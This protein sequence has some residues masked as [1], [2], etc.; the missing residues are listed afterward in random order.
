MASMI[1]LKES[2]VVRYSPMEKA[3]IKV[4]ERQPEKKAD[5]ELLT[6]KVY[7][8]LDRTP[9]RTARN[10]MSGTVRSL[11]KKLDKNKEEIKLIQTPFAGPYATKVAIVPRLARAAA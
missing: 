10:I 3:I 1:K 8:V 2:D 5:M 6:E 11:T 9:P 4:L 7:R